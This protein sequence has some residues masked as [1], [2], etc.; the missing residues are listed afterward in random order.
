METDLDKVKNYLRSVRDRFDSI[1]IRVER[2][3]KW[4]SKYL[5]ECSIKEIFDWMIFWID[6]RM[7]K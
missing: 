1:P 3:G 4:V 2:D 6:T 7:V 5:S